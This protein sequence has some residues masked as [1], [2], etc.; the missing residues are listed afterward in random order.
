SSLSS[1]PTHPFSQDL[2]EPYE[3]STLQPN[4]IETRRWVKHR[5]RREQMERGKKKKERHVHTH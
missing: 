4:I 2:R 3:S 5:G 1:L